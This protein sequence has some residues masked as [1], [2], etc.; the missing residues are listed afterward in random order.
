MSQEQNRNYK[1]SYVRNQVLQRDLRFKRRWRFRYSTSG[2]TRRVILELLTNVSEESTASISNIACR[3]NPEDQH[4][5][6]SFSISS[7]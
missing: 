7:A 3:I 2:V 5:N 6:Q 1:C 4:L